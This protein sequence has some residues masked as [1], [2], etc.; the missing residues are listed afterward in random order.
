MRLLRRLQL[1]LCESVVLKE[2]TIVQ[3][4]IA[5]IDPYHYRVEDTSCCIDLIDRS[6]ETIAGDTLYDQS[7]RAKR[8]ERSGAHS[9]KRYR[10]PRQSQQM[11]SLVSLSHHLGW[12]N[13]VLAMLRYAGAMLRWCW[14]MLCWCYAGA[15]LGWC[16][17][18][19]WVCCLGLLLTVAFSSG[20]S[21]LIHPVST[22]FI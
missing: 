8:T 21:S 22:E 6:L 3:L 9:T 10:Q 15:M 11:A 17:A 20:F 1:P 16:Y 18:G 7:K 12:L 14:A 13:L 4:L 2:Y 5:M 19:L